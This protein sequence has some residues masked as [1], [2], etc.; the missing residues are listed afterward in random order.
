MRELCAR[1]FRGGSLGQT[2][3]SEDSVWAGR[4]DDL[5]ADYG[6]SLPLFSSC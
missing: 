2:D 6:R 1:V 4:C 5:L 3:R